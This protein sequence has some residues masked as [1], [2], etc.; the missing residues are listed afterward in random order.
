[1]TSGAVKGPPSRYE[2]NDKGW[3]L[4][5]PMGYMQDDNQQSPVPHASDSDG[6]FYEAIEE[7]P[8]I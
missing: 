4:P 5:S 3:Y 1:M 6:I 2:T 7:N 8:G